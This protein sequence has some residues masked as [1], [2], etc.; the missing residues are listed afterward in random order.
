MSSIGPQDVREHCDISMTQ[1][2]ASSG[3]DNHIGTKMK[4]LMGTGTS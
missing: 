4:K 2:L 3:H 1:R